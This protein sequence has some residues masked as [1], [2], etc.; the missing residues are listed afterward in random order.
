VLTFFCES[1][2]VLSP[3]T[4]TIKWQHAAQQWYNPTA[5]PTC[6]HCDYT[7]FP[8]RDGYPT[9]SLH[10]AQYV[11]R[12]MSVRGQSDKLPGFHT[13][14]PLECLDEITLYNIDFLPWVML[15][16]FCVLLF[17]D[18]EYVPSPTILRGLRFARRFRFKSWSSRLWRRVVVQ[19]QYTVSNPGRPRIKPIIFLRKLHICQNIRKYATTHKHSSCRMPSVQ[20]C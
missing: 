15:S 2:R 13:Q 17:A 1:W 5:E 16:D 3:L 19:Y 12:V 11:I 7:T 10:L 4:T 9:T 6:L 8:E 20:L 18:Y 14:Y